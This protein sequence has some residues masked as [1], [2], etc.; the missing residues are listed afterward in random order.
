MEPWSQLT[1][2]LDDSWYLDCDMEV[3]MERVFDRFLTMGLCAHDA[4]H[5]LDD[6]D[7]RNAE[8]IASC[9]HRAQLIIRCAVDEAV[10]EAIKAEE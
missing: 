5:R 6:N 3:A 2:L 8:L 9:A 1:D 7:S 10:D 4:Q